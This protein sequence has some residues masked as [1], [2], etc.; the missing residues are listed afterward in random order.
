MKLV[1]HVSAFQNSHNFSDVTAE[2]SMRGKEKK[3][4]NEK[5]RINYVIVFRLWLHDDHA[6]NEESE[7]AHLFSVIAVTP[8]PK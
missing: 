5:V 6:E 3:Q 1:N 4:A 8:K 7:L 2:G